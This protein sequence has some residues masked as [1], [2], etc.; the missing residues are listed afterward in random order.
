MAKI[1][2]EKCPARPDQ[3]DILELESKKKEHSDRGA[4]S[5][6]PSALGGE[7]Q[8]GSEPNAH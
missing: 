8:Q 7:H 2:S 3:F 1:N 4:L 5:G 6:A